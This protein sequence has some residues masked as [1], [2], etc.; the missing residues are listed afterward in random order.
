MET[1]HGLR[2]LSYMKNCNGND[3]YILSDID[4][5]DTRICPKEA[6]KDVKPFEG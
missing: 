6:V 2:Q 5:D 4:N 1:R 3:R